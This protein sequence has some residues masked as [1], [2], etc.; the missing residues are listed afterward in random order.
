MAPP[1]NSG[2][3]APPLGVSLFPALL[4]GIVLAIAALWLARRKGRSQWLALLAF[5]PGL[6]FLVFLYLLSLTDKRV[7][8]DIEALKKRIGNDAKF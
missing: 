1:P 5:I 8:D 6:G 2:T 7:L 4:L 3:P